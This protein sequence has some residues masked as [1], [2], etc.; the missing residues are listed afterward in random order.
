MHLPVPR[1]FST[2]SAGMVFVA[3][4]EPAHARMNA[5]IEYKSFL[6][7]LESLFCSL[8]GNTADKMKLS[9]IS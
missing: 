8:H 2:A 7:L 9:N 1:L 6:K 4:D 3:S 5:E